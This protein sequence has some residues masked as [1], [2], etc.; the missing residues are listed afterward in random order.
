MIAVCFDD[1]ENMPPKMCCTYFQLV[2]IN[3]QKRDWNVVNDELKPLKLN[4]H[5][6]YNLTIF[7]QS[8]VNCMPNAMIFYS[9]YFED[10]VIAL[11][12]LYNDSVCQMRDIG[13][14]LAAL[15][16]NEGV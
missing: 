9:K 1:T 16:F 12:S 13:L 15:N 5:L 10:K 8:G 2:C 4:L 7:L 11:F 3:T 14:N 6:P